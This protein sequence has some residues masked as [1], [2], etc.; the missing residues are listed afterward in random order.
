[1]LGVFLFMFFVFL[2]TLKFE[3]FACSD[4]Q[5]HGNSLIILFVFVVFILFSFAVL[6]LFSTSILKFVASFNVVFFLP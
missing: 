4:D 6:C 1:M 3:V 5:Y 2:S